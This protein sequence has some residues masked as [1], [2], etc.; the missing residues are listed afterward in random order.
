[1]SDPLRGPGSA[2]SSL[3]AGLAGGMARRWGLGERP[4]AADLLAD[5]PHLADS[6]DAVMGLVYEEL[7]LR[8]RYGKPA[9]AADL[10]RRFP[11]WR[12]ELRVLLDCHRLLEG[13]PAPD[14]PGAG[15]TLGGFRLLAELG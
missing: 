1:M 12:A 15:E 14:L 13:S 8:Q 6:V 3:V 11:R 4:P 2:S 5:A 9:E 7:A 10:V